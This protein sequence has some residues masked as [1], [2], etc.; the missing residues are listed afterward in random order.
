MRQKKLRA[1]LW[2][3]A[4]LIAGTIFA[5]IFEAPAAA[6]YVCPS[7]YGLEKLESGLYIE[8][9]ASVRDIADLKSRIAIA[10]QRLG[11]FYPNLAAAPTL[12]VCVSPGCGARL[13]GKGAKAMTYGVFFV[14]V[15]PDGRNETILAHELAHVELHDR[16]GN[17]ALLR[18]ALPAWFD[19]GLA[20]I[21]SRDERYLTPN[22]AA[23]VD[24]GA[25]DAGDLPVSSRDWRRQA[26]AAT[27][28]LY[29]LAACR[30]LEWM[31]ARGGK[32]AIEVL[33][34]QLRAGATFR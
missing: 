6:A 32:K 28:P 29:A 27:R 16:I 14:R 8:S 10:K 25:Q 12:L 11:E 23:K 2:S 15:S 31:D 18:G 13:G 19:E 21:V 20:V 9:G 24:C 7:C 26:G 4:F 22:A 30:V 34:A 5:V 17:L 3:I 33:A 1:L